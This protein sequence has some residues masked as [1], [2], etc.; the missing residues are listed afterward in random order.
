MNEL[1]ILVDLSHCSEAT[2]L[3]AIDTSTKPVAIT[4]SFCK[5]L[6]DHDRGK[7]DDV[8]RALG[9]AGGYFGILTV[10]FFITTE[11]TATLDH[12]VA[13][14]D[15]VVDLIGPQH[16]GIGTDWGVHFPKPLVD[17]LN[18]EMARL[19]FREEH[20][21]DW[22][23]TVE[24]FRDWREWPNITRALVSRGY[25]DEQIEGFLGG[26]FLRVFERAVA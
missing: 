18:E 3:D 20:R 17:M 26:N 10:P 14:F 21:V 2:T 1:G 19:G 9:E 8:I 12:F 25:S 22:G 11:P 7:S 13:H 4:H 24:G 23:A 15:R 6:S 16:V 5:A